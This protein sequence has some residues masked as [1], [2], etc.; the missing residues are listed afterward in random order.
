MFYRRDQLRTTKVKV[1]EP[2]R[3]PVQVAYAASSCE[4]LM[5]CSFMISKIHGLV[6]DLETGWE[7]VML[8]YQFINTA[9][10]GIIGRKD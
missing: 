6:T 4:F 8:A 10:V 1:I 2:S 7:L 3:P 5:H 9:Y